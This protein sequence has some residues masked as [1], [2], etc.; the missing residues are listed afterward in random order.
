MWYKL[1]GA[2]KETLVS[3]V[4]GH[5]MDN[6]SQPPPFYLYNVLIWKRELENPFFGKEFEKSLNHNW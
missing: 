6:F 5:H 1:D 3:L 2:R 4:E